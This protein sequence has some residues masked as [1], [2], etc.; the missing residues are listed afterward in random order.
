MTAKLYRGFSTAAAY[1]GQRGFALSGVDLVNRDILNHIY[2][3]PGERVMM[4]AFGTRIPGLAFEPLDEQTLEVVRR[5]LAA[6]VAAE[7]RVALLDM[8]VM[9]L[10]DNSAI[11]ALLDL[12]Y[13]EL[14]SQ[15]TLRLEFP[16]G[17]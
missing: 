4:P 13:L 15:E 3:S 10:P 6:V 8:V 14:D 12:Q 5:D 2:T 7:P 11:V 1:E 17:R 9:A 16:A